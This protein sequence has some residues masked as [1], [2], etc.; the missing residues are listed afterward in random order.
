MLPLLKKQNLTIFLPDF[1]SLSKILRIININS[2]AIKFLL[3]EYAF[4]KINKI[5]QILHENLNQYGFLQ[6]I[7]FLFPIQ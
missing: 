6:L 4:Q 1:P 7:V 5:I 3:L 2:I